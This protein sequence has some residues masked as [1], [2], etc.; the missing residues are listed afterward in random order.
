MMMFGLGTSKD[1]NRAIDCLRQASERGNIYV[2]QDGFSDTL[3]RMSA[4]PRPWVCWC[5]PII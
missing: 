3:I 4:V 1:I 2:S 5:M